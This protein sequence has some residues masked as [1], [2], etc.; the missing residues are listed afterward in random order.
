MNPVRFDRDD[1]PFA[2]GVKRR[3]QLVLSDGVRTRVGA[4]VTEAQHIQGCVVLGHRRKARHVPRS[5]VAVEG[6]KQSAV[7]QG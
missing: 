3:S 4:N 1:M 7:K 2:A 5:L 6:V